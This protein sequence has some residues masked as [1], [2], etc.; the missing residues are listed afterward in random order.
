MLL[1]AIL[2]S[3]QSSKPP[4]EIFFS[5]DFIPRTH[6]KGSHSVSQGGPKSERLKLSRD[7]E[8]QRTET[9]ALEDQDTD[10][11]GWELTLAVPAPA[12]WSPATD[13]A[14][15]IP[16]NM[17]EVFSLQSLT[18]LGIREQQAGTHSRCQLLIKIKSFWC[19]DLRVTQI[20]LEFHY[21]SCYS[22]PTCSL[23]HLRSLDWLI[24][25]FTV[26]LFIPLS[27]RMLCCP[28]MTILVPPDHGQ[29]PASVI[30]ERY[31]TFS[32]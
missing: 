7:S 8:D 4:A 17:T 14:K 1:K 18:H 3:R 11:P 13:N 10:D 28:L 32:I 15:A 22:L 6:T 19:A 5:K 21:K 31:R 30:A 2:N 16:F 12:P 25:V 24:F 23:K 27:S 26:P 29:E 9:L 20:S